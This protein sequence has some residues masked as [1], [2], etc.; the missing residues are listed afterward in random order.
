M[1]DG[2]VERFGKYE[3][4]EKIAAG[5]M[6][7]VYRAR[8]RGAA[9]FEKILVIKKILPH[10]A[11]DKEFQGLFIDEARIAVQLVHVNIVQVFDL[12]E[13]DGQ[14]FMA[15]EFVNGL[16]LSRLLSKARTIGE[17][18]IPYALFLI[19]EVLKA[20][21]FAHHRRDDKGKL[22]NIVHCDISPQNILVSYSG[23][24][25][26]T[27]F[28]ISRA[29]FQMEE[30]HQVIRGKYAYMAPEQVEG[31][32]LNGQTDVFALS[33]VLFEM[34]TGR[35]LFKAKDRTETLMRVRRADIPSLQQFRPEISEA[36]EKVVRKGLARDVKDRYQTAGEMLEALSTIMMEENHRATSNDLAAFIRE[37]ID[38]EQHGGT[39]MTGSHLS[40]RA[41]DLLPETVVVCAAEVVIPPRSLATP[42][43]S[44]SELMNSWSNII[45]KS[46]GE[47]WERNDGSLV[48]IWKAQDSLEA[49]CK[50]VVSCA[51]TLRQQ[52]KNA[53]YR[54]SI[55]IAPGVARLSSETQRPGEGWEL[56]GPFYMARW[57]MN[58]SAHRSR[59]LMTEVV[60]KSLDEGLK[61]LAR[62]AVNN[63][64][65]ISLYEL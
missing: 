28:G 20:L 24:V 56:A 17:F 40:G 36:L 44:S 3:L 12:G 41:K 5:G 43:L 48:A 14:Y 26:L 16:D 31:K 8:S 62:I 55:G 6:A 2:I 25:K 53:Q 39:L 52:S 29:A 4:I 22:L 63:E 37:V 30:Q 18:P 1:T 47:I 49:T 57:M 11:N 60:A 34:L 35:R 42:K 38:F 51:Q 21:Q 23:E 19:S 46:K 59:M 9:G 27:D 7:E 61:P 10:L 13:I 50:R 65:S 45:K 33:I 64:R 58:L 15:M 32:I 54:S